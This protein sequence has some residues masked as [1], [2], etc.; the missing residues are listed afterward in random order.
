MVEQP[1]NV[2][3]A[4]ESVSLSWRSLI[5]IESGNA[6]PCDPSIALATYCLA[7]ESDLA[8][9][10]ENHPAHGG[11]IESAIGSVVLGI[12]IGWINYEF[13]SI[14]EYSPSGATGRS[15]SRA[16]AASTTTFAAPFFTNL[17][18]EVIN[19]NMSNFS[20]PCR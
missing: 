10:H 7:I 4:I 16:S 20:V 14:R 1:V 19:T 13:L 17:Q 15:A 11:L 9:D 8:N 12:A 18:E 5:A 3:N 6:N 2:I